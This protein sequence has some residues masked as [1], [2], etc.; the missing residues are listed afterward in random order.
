MRIYKNSI[1]V[2]AIISIASFITS[3]LL[4]FNFMG[5]EAE[6]CYDISMGVFSGAILTLI[7]SIIGYRVERRKVLEAFWSYTH[8][9]LHQIN[10]YQEKMTLEQK[11]DFFINFHDTDRIEWSNA[12]GEISF[13]FDWKRKNFLYIYNSI[14]KPIYDLCN[15]I[16]SHYW[17]F[18]WHK[19]GSGR[20]EKV[21]QYYIDEIEPL[22]I[23]RYPE[24][25]PTG[26]DEEVNA[27]SKMIY[28]K[29]HNR[30]VRNITD[31]L[32]NKYY[33]IMYGKRTYKKENSKQND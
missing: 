1:I 18:K 8:K 9:V 32:Y 12:L 19:D 6:F 23:K 2:T 24:E 22:I 31:E 20:N 16:A 3:F 11:V 14:Y 21:M 33:I 17:K 10:M 26:A 7:T 25:I 29:V 5:K 30:L 28:A 27:I 15:V 13:L 4:K